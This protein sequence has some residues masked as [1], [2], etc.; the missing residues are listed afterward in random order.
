MEKRPE[1]A[2][3][4]NDTRPI[5]LAV[6]IVVGIFLFHAT[7]TL[8]FYPLNLPDEFT[9]NF[10]ARH[11]DASEIIIPNFLY[12]MIIK[13]CDLFGDQYYNAVKVINSLVFVSAAPFIYMISRMVCGRNLSLY[14]CVIVLCWPTSIY[15]SQF[16][17]EPF[18][19]TAGWIFFWVMLRYDRLSPLRQGMLAGFCIALFSLIKVHGAFMLPG[20]L[21][22]ILFTFPRPDWRRYCCNVVKSVFAAAVAFLFVKFGIAFLFA[23]NYGITLFGKG[24]EELANE[25]ASSILSMGRLIVDCLYNLFG[26]ILVASLVISLPI[27]AVYYVFVERTA[28]PARLKRLCCIAILF[29]I[30]YVGISAGFSGMLMQLFPDDYPLEATRIQARYYSFFY[31]LF[32]VI[33]GG[34]MS[35]LIPGSEEKFRRGKWLACVLV[36]MAAYAAFSGMHGY[37]SVMLEDYPEGA[38]LRI[39]PVLPLLIALLPMTA[40]LLSFVRAKRAFQLYLFAFLPLYC[41]ASI[42]VLH[43]GQIMRGIF[44]NL[45]DEAGI[46]VREYLGDEVKDVAIVDSWMHPAKKAWMHMDNA[47]VVLLPH[48]DTDLVDMSRIPPNKKW[49]LSFGI[50]KIPEEYDKFHIFYVHPAQTKELWDAMVENDRTAAFL[51]YRLT[52]IRDFD[53]SFDF[54]ADKVLWPVRGAYVE[55]TRANILYAKALPKKMRLSLTLTDEVADMDFLIKAGEHELGVLNGAG[56]ELTATVPPESFVLSFE[57][58]GG[59]EDYVKYIAG[60]HLAGFVMNAYEAK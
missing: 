53:Y 13:V 39:M 24:Y 1:L 46:F 58:V 21:L 28:V 22:F 11:H 52:R 9:Y 16:W 34:V 51:A 49:V 55:G 4:E 57:P 56:S 45:Y 54:S 32:P 48:F 33:A 23:G 17:P 35:I 14:L 41:V 29:L 25:G 8:N 20:Y 60:T 43:M 30:P 5:V 27:M 19:F 6:V 10:D 44:P 38:F 12:Y 31:P 37:D 47:E 50:F 18:Y 59:G 3:S 2:D 26:H 40:C 36:V 42:T 7:R 15:T